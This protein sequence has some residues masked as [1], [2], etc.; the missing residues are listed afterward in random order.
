[1]ILPGLV[2]NFYGCSETDLPDATTRK[3]AR[4][5]R[6]LGDSGTFRIEVRPIRGQWRPLAET[7]TSRK[8]C[9]E[10]ISRD[11]AAGES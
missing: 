11:F 2:V 6:I 4:E 7:V 5:Y 9:E 3:N 1:M 10:I 8:E